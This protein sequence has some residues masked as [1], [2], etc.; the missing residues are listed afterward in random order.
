MEPQQRRLQGLF[1]FLQMSAETRGRGQQHTGGF[2]DSRP[3]K[4][5]Q[6]ESYMKT[7]ILLLPPELLR[8]PKVFYFQ[9]PLRSKSPCGALKA[10]H[11]PMAIVDK[12][13]PEDTDQSCTGEHS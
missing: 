3:A 1:L 8:H 7:C 6:G 10:L 4:D 11:K 13:Q 2:P 9:L 12:Q 5:H